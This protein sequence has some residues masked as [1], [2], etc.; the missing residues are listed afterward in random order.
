MR[1]IISNL[2]VFGGYGLH[3]SLTAFGDRVKVVNVPYSDMQR[4][5]SR[6]QYTLCLS[7]DNPRDI[8]GIEGGLCGAQPIYPHS[9]FFH[10]QFPD[11]LGVKFFDLSNAYAELKEIFQAPVEWNTESCFESFAAS[12]NVPAFWQHVIS[13]LSKDE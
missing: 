10:S 12:A 9:D 6:L 2:S 5:L 1:G 4:E 11:A 7:T 13:C 3:D 8:I